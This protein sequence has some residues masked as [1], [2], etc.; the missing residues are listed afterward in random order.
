MKLTHVVQ[1][2]HHV[3]EGEEHIARQTDLVADLRRDG[4]DSGEARR[5]LAQLIVS[6]SVH[7]DNCARLERE[8]FEVPR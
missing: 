5:L 4:H 6:Q 1:A 3:A 8:L 7:I 2:R